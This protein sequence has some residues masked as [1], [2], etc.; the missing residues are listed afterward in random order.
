MQ[1]KEIERAYRQASGK[2]IGCDWP[3][4]FGKTGLDLNGLKASQVLLLARAT[5]GSERADWDAAATWLTRLEQE[6]G[7]AEDE[8]KQAV[9]PVLDLTYVSTTAVRNPAQ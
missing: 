3:T 5:S 8:A 2:W 9:A 1:A 4:E 7:K 6:A